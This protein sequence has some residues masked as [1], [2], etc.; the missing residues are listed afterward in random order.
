MRPPLVTTSA[1]CAPGSTASNSPPRPIHAERTPASSRWSTSRDPQFERA[2][3]E[4]GLADV[5]KTVAGLESG[6]GRAAAAVYAYEQ[7]AVHARSAGDSS[8]EQLMLALT[9][10]EQVDGP[11]PVRGGARVARHARCPAP[12]RAALPR[13][14]TCSRAALEAMLGNFDDARSLLGGMF[15]RFAELGMSHGGA[16]SHSWFVEETL[17]RDHA[18]AER[19]ARRGLEQVEQAGDVGASSTF[20]CLLA[21]SLTTSAGTKR[22]QRP[23]R[24]AKSSAP[25]MTL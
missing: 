4:L 13:G 15:E 17:A 11:T 2:G 5:G 21:R 19:E 16:T 8:L 14:G 22:L 12:A 18:A 20:V 9:V 23:L 1:L 24:S 7:A 25:A 6:D 10:H 3:D